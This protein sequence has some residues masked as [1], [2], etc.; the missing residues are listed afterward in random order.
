MNCF[1]FLSKILE[2]FSNRLLYC[3]IE[4]KAGFRTYDNSEQL[5]LKILCTD[6]GHITNWHGVVI[7][8][9]LIFSPIV[10]F[11]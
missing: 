8:E 7:L 3:D 1:L 4:V 9:L 10:V 2:R 11:M 6:P 5:L